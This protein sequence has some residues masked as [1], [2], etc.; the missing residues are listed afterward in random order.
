[1]K[2]EEHVPKSWHREAVENYNAADAELEDL[3]GVLARWPAVACALVSGKPVRNLDELM[4][5]TE[6][7]LGRTTEVERLRRQMSIRRQ[8]DPHV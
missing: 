5:A 4:V 3:K 1:M 2:H 8:L 7:A 6:M